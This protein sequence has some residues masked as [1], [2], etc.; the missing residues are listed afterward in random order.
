[1]A[2]SKTIKAR[3]IG[4]QSNPGEPVPDL[5]DAYGTTFEAGKFAEV[6]EAYA[7]KVRG[8]PH[9]EVQGE[10]RAAA[11]AE[12]AESTADFSARVATITDRDGLEQMLETEK[13]P[14]AKKVIEQRLNA[15]PA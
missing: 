7:D 1:M 10:K 2:E 5:V 6:D 13:R 3:F 12:T 8:N 4:D 11:T 15:L 14:H 9:F